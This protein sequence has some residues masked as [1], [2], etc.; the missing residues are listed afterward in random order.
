MS[1]Q[2]NKTPG[3]LMNENRAKAHERFSDPGSNFGA[4]TTAIPGSPEAADAAITNSLEHVRQKVREGKTSLVI[5][6]RVGL[7]VDGDVEFGA[8]FIR[9]KM[10]LDALAYFVNSDVAPRIAEHIC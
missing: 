9:L 2:E 7:P 1:D 8:E 4:A 5:V 6:A 3:D 10:P